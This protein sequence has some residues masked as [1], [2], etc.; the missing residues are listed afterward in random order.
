MPGRATAYGAEIARLVDCREALVEEGLA[1]LSCGAFHVR[2]GGRA[3]FNTTPL[4][5]A[6]AG[7]L[8]VRA[9]LARISESDSSEEDI[10]PITS[11]LTSWGA[12][13]EEPAALQPVTLARMALQRTDLPGA[14]PALARAARSSG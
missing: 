8:L 6:V 12:V 11:L 9:M 7:T 3:Y 2:T 10:D 14:V 1:A 4:G 5:R 13:P